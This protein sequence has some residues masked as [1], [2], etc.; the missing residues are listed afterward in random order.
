MDLAGA[1]TQL[2]A[3]A[4]VGGRFLNPISPPL[5]LVMEAV[6]PIPPRRPS[7]TFPPPKKEWRRGSSENTPPLTGS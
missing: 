5:F 1:E 4:E 6:D 3:G 2:E 7:S